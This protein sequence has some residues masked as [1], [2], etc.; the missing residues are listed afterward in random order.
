LFCS[1]ISDNGARKRKAKV[2]MVFAL[3]THMT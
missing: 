1:F 2:V 3:Y